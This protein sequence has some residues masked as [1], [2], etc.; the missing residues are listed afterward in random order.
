MKRNNLYLLME[1]VNNLN[2][3][4]LNINLFMFFIMLG[5][6]VT[7]IT[8]LMTGTG[9]MDVFIGF[10]VLIFCTLLWFINSRIHKPKVIGVILVVSLY[11]INIPLLVYLGRFNYCVNIIWATLLL[12]VIFCILNG[13]QFFVALMLFIFEFSYIYSNLVLKDEVL[14][15]R[16]V[17]RVRTETIA[18]SFLG[19]AF[20]ICIIIHSQEKFYQKKGMI[21]RENRKKIEHAGTAKSQFLS[22]MSYEIRTPMNAII[23]DSEILLRDHL[24]GEEKA[25]VNTIRSASYELLSII[26]DVLTYAKIDAKKL[27]LIEKSYS[28]E[29]LVLEIANVFSEEIYKKK[30]IMYV[31]IDPRIPRMLQGDKV[32]I[33]QIFLYLLFISLDVTVTGRVMLEVRFEKN[34]D[35][36]SATLK[37]KVAD[38]GRGLSEIDI[39]ALFGMYD[40]YDS[41]QSSDLKGIGLKYSICHSLLEMMGG[42]IE[43][44]SIKGIGLCTNFTFVNEII[45]ETPMISIEDEVLPKVLIY[46]SNDTELDTWKELMGGFGIR[47]TYVR[48]YY[49]LDNAIQDIHYNFIFIPAEVYENVS[50]IISLYGCEESTYITADYNAIYGDFGKCR[51]VH[52]PFSCISIGKVLNHKWSKEE[53][54]KSAL[55]ESF[56]AK[57]AKVLVVDDNVVNLKVVAGIFSKY[58]IDIAVATCGEDGLKKIKEDHYDLILMDMAMPDMSGDEVLHAVRELDDKYYKEVP[59]VALTAQNGASVREEMISYGFQEYLSKPIKRRYL[60]KCLLDFLPEKLIEWVK[61]DDKVKTNVIEDRSGN[62]TPKVESGLNTDKGMLNI[63]FNQDAYAAILNTYYKEGM[64]Y[65]DILPSILESQNIQLFTTTV[66]GIKSSSASIGAMEVSALFKEL[67]FAGKDNKVDEIQEKFAPYMEKFKEIL[68]LVKK[69][70]VSKGKF[71]KEEVTE[72]LE[73]KET[74]ILTKDMLAELKTELD[75]MNL[76]VTDAMVADYANRNFGKEQNDKIKNLKEAYDMFDFHQV[77]IIVNEMIEAT[78]VAE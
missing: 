58:G 69:Y 74:E 16:E 4:E 2:F 8:R 64:K 26:D 28:F 17:G 10:C 51:L 30:L 22:N 21:I 52:R 18:L 23:N 43:V 31:R 49:G 5:N 47:P 1:K 48:N 37:C 33:R 7:I 77:K 78:Q 72:N 63:G 71:V 14:L 15:M 60:E 19:I 65:L 61:I 54:K 55:T 32:I 38:T 20:F 39:Q 67:E 76:K 35:G 6:V 68:E 41:R 27:N 13:V 11:M 29:E 66:H 62:G 46:V 75:K 50:N 73:E 45:D 53:Y 59:V 70:L 34:D 9:L 56:K 57:N 25:A 40:T 36:K 44:E 42:T 3:E 12:I 24:E